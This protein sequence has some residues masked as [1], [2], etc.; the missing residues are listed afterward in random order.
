MPPFGFIYG[1]KQGDK[2]RPLVPVPEQ[3][4]VIRRIKR[5]SAKGWTPRRIAEHL[6]ERGE[7]LSGVTVR[8]V[9]AGR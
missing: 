6:R 8:K 5:L 9:L 1:G 3:Q 4:A 7:Y 2:H